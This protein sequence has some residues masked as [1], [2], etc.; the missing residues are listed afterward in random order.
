MPVTTYTYTNL[1][2]SKNKVTSTMTTPPTNAKNPPSFV[3]PV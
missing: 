3:V 1:M 2:M